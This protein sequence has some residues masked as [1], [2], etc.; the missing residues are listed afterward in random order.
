MI[1]NSTEKIKDE[2]KAIQTFS[3]SLDKTCIAS[4]ANAKL[5]RYSNIYPFDYNRV[6]LNDDEF[7]NDYI[8]AS[9][10]NVRFLWNLNPTD[11]IIVF[12]Q[13]YHCPREYIATQGPKSNTGHDF[14][15]M[16]L[17]H[18][19]ESIVMLTSL[20]ENNLVKCHEYF[21]KLNGQI[22]FANIKVT[23][24]YEESQANF[25]KRIMDV[26]KVNLNLQL[27]NLFITKLILNI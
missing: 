26:E 3:D 7:E 20:I 5:N 25:I 6:V 21:P 11:L 24:R 10:I 27:K 4:I 18:K 15:R 1:D 14:W 22:T 17:Q 19:A 16:V 8:N 9:Y 13:G 12:P 23:C 2:Y